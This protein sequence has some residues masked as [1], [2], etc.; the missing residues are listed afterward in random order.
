MSQLIS[1]AQTRP[2]KLFGGWAASCLLTVATILFSFGA[3]HGSVAQSAEVDVVSASEV[4]AE[5]ILSLGGALTEIVY[6]LNA[7][8]QLVGVDM[9]SRYPEAAQKLPDVGY[10]RRLSAEPVVALSPTLILASDQAGP[11]EVFAQIEDAGIKVVRVP[12]NDFKEDVGGKVRQVAQLL[13]R[14]AEGE[15]LAA[16]LDQQMAALVR[17]VASAPSAK[18]RIVSLMSMGRGA[19][20]AAGK[21]TIAHHLIEL[22]GGENAFADFNGYKP[23]ADEALIAAAPEIILV[24]SHILSRAGGLAGVKETP[25]IAQTPAGKTDKVIVVDSETALG[26]GPRFPQAARKLAHL[27]HPEISLTSS[28]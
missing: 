1:L 20:Q 25:S 14:T 23:V 3:I 11:P 18:P 8:D 17:D 21:G 5:R 7:Q 19:L 27:F 6:A 4:K 16:D 13:N 28:K 2:V 15:L 12:E 22:A 9:T 10:F 24:P 26:Y